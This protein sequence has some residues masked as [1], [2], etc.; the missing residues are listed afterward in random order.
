MVLK[1]WLFKYRFIIY[2][3]FFNQ[4]FFLMNFCWKIT[5][6]TWP[7]QGHTT[8]LTQNHKRIFD[9][10]IN[11]SSIIL[12]LP[13]QEKRT[14]F[15]WKLTVLLITLASFQWKL[16]VLLLLFFITESNATWCMVQF[17]FRTVSKLLIDISSNKTLWISIY[18]SS[19]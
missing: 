16:T 7:L 3:F 8:R 6:V 19:F 2:M 5:R 4:I 14:S 11:H 1:S 13:F 18:S 9:P 12:K 15:Q 10:K 17:I